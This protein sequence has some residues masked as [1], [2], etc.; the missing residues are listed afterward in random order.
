MAKT[1]DL[2]LENVL[3]FQL[4]P[5]PPA[6]FEATNVLRKP[7]KPQLAHAIS[8]YM[9]SE[10]Q[11]ECN[12]RNE[13]YVVDGGSLLHRIPR[14]K[15]DSY[16]EIAESYADFTIQ[17]YGLA[18]VVFDGYTRGPSIKDNTHERRT[19]I[20]FVLLLALLL[21]QNLLAK[22]KIFCLG[23]PTSRTSLI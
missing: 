18:T 7:N 9:I 3:D 21:K 11:T 22:K 2:S 1:D 6:L 8:E 19:N 13:H 15:G 5:Y 10:A 14:T 17:H 12:H 20:K 16:G 23:Q 4:S